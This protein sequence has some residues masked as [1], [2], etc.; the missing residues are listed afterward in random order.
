MSRNSKN[1]Y[2]FSGFTKLSL[3]YIQKLTTI[4]ISLTEEFFSTNN[5]ETILEEI[6][7][8][9]LE[10]LDVWEG[11]NLHINN[12]SDHKFSFEQNQLSFLMHYI[13]SGPYSC[14]CSSC[15]TSKVPKA[16][17]YMRD[18]LGSFQLL[19]TLLEVLSK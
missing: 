14:S 6:N 12:H 9:S 11:L 15:I 3:E 13:R 18:V 8:K 1:L 16:T 10:M 2:E 17:I 5:K 4:L 7:N 19:K